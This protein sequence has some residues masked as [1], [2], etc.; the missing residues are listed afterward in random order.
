M[1]KKFVQKL[2][3]T[4]AKFVKKEKVDL[5]LGNTT[6]IFVGGVPNQ[7]TIAEFSNYFLK[8]GNIRRIQFPCDKNNQSLN[9]GFGFINYYDSESAD[10]VLN[11]PLKHIIRAK[12]VRLLGRC[13]NRSKKIKE[14]QKVIIDISE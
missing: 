2:K 5:P 10:K 12:E 4:R 11:Y 13:K 14:K 3:V 1:E 7:T 9:C 8:F 6:K